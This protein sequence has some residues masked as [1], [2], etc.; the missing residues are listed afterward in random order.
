MKIENAHGINDH[1]ASKVKRRPSP[2][3][4]LILSNSRRI[5]NC[6]KTNTVSCMDTDS[7]E[8]EENFWDE[9]NKAVHVAEVLGRRKHE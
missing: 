5:T 1:E 7:I 6:F 4:A 3:G 2:L 8:F 9:L